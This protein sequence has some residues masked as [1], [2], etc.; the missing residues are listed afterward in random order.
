M[1]RCLQLPKNL[2]K[3][4]SLSSE[5]QVA[6]RCCEILQQGRCGLGEMLGVQADQLL[7]RGRLEMPITGGFGEKAGQRSARAGRRP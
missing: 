2:Q 4:F 7:P 6:K 3:R 5:G 1:H